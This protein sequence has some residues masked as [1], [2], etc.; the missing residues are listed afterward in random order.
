MENQVTKKSG[1]M[2]LT[3]L[4]N[5]NLKYSGITVKSIRGIDVKAGWNWIKNM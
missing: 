3:T 1:D 5:D 4:K 2:I